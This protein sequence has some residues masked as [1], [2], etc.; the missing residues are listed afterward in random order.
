[1]T[2]HLQTMASTTCNNPS[3]SYSY[4]TLVRAIYMHD[5]STSVFLSTAAHI[6]FIPPPLTQKRHYSDYKINNRSAY[7][8]R[9]GE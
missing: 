2:T 1:M 6:L 3:L 7:V 4:V 5:Q 8:L 9:D